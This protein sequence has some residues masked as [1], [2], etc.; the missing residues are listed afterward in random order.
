MVVWFEPY[1]T[2]TGDWS[3]VIPT[4]CS[5]PEQMESNGEIQDVREVLMLEDIATQE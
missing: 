5:T 1:R 4:Y 3:K 2:N